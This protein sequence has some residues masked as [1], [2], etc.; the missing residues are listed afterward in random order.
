MRKNPPTVVEAVKLP[1]KVKIAYSAC[2]L[3]KTTITI[4]IAAFLLFFYT[5]VCGIKPEIAS[6]IVLIAKI[7]DIINDPMMGALVDKTKSKE[8]KCR[9]Y[10]KYFS[11]PVAVVTVLTFFMPDISS[12]GKIIYVAVT[13][14][15]QGMLST[16]VLIPIN[17]LMGRLTLDNQ[18]R[19]QISQIGIIFSTAA[20]LFA[21][22]YAM[23]IVQ[24]IGGGDMQKGFFWLSVI[25]G[26]IYVASIMITYFG[27]QGYEPV[28]PEVTATEKEK[29]SFSDVMKALVQNKVWVACIGMD[30]FINLSTATEAAALTFYLTYNIKDLDMF[31]VYSWMSTITALVVGGL[32]LT[33]F[34]K[35][36]GNAGTAMLGCLL[37]VAGPLIRFIMHDS[38]AA[39]MIIGWG[40]AGLGLGLATGVAFLNIFDARSY[41]EWKNGFAN[42]AVL[43][44][45]YSVSYKT[46]QAIATPL[47][48]CMMGMVPYVANAES[49]A[50][51][52]LD[53]FF[54]QNTL[55]P[56]IGYGIAALC[57]VV[58]LKN[59][60]NMPMILK[61]LEERK[62]KL[63]VK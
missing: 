21:T 50:Q 43:M 5:D 44:A 27:T 16:A 53:V 17:T 31:P 32:L 20:K 59:Q 14:I 48:G 42:D 11:V 9:A 41:G 34:T 52:V 46:G 39:V 54:Y 28:E 37:A 47:V 49:Q 60:K 26:V 33:Q 18:E 61:E 38:S 40:L 45:G 1:M 23:K 25:F 7:W 51:S 10:L 63:S 4:L 6:A 3:A 13:Y 8:G 15:L 35:R 57:G 24:A 56:M 22:G 62:N 30:F 55:L 36:L 58:L 12:T 19:A 2:N 29:V